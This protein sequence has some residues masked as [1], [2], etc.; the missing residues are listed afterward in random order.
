MGRVVK[1]CDGAGLLLTLLLRLPGAALL[2]WGAVVLDAGEADPETKPAA[3]QNE[4]E[5]LGER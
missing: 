3:V 5:P 2:L 1:C 4:R